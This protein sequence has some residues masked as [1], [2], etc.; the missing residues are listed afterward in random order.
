VHDAVSSQS[1]PL[2]KRQALDWLSGE[3]EMLD[4][5]LSLTDISQDM[6]LRRVK[7]MVLNNINLRNMYSDQFDRSQWLQKSYLIDNLV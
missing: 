3:N 1:T 2:I 7:Y 5:C 6:L 4:T